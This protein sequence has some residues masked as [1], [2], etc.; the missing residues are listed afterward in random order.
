MLEIIVFH[1]GFQVYGIEVDARHL[2]LVAD[3]MTWSGTYRALNRKGLEGGTSPLQQLSF[4][5]ALTFLKTSVQQNSSDDL[6]SPSARLCL[7]LPSKSGTGAF[8]LLH[9]LAAH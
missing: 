2:S 5:A 3:Y 9:Q 4:E 7:G 8:S 6:S 1:C